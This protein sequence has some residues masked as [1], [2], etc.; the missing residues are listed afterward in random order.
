LLERWRKPAHVL[1]VEDVSNQSYVFGSGR[2][3]NACAVTLDDE[4]IE[5]MRLGH[6]CAKCF[7][8]FEHAWPVRCPT[9]GAPVRDKQAEYFAKEFGGEIQIGGSSLEIDGIHERARKEH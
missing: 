8:P 7:E 1:L 5:R 3:Q 6:M 2:V 4:T 9:C